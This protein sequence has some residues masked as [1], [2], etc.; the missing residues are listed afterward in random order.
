[1]YPIVC[2]ERDFLIDSRVAQIARV[3]GTDGFESDRGLLLQRRD[4][5]SEQ[6]YLMHLI[7]DRHRIV[8]NRM[9]LYRLCAQPNPYKKREIV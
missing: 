4:F 2:D 9:Q 7:L 6:H 1:M 5:D 8:L 3:G